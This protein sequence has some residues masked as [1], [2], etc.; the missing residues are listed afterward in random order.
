M[1][2]YLP[3]FCKFPSPK[4][5]LCSFLFCFSFF[6]GSYS[7]MDRFCVAT[8]QIFTWKVLWKIFSNIFFLS[9]Y[10]FFQT[11]L[12]E[13]LLKCVCLVSRASDTGRDEQAFKMTCHCEREVVKNITWLWKKPICAKDCKRSC[14]EKG[15]CE[16]HVYKIFTGNCDFYFEYKIIFRNK[17]SAM[18]VVV[19]KNSQSG[20]CF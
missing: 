17:I 18:A 3:G 6:T 9:G 12:L 1:L 16:R 15:V 10:P 19:T 13:I 7:S 14:S 5:F 4:W 11:A 2:Y 20:F 8:Q